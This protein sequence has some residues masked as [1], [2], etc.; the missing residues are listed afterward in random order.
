MCIKLTPETGARD[1]VRGAIGHVYNLITVAK[2]YVIVA[3][4]SLWR[5]DTVEAPRAKRDGKY[6]R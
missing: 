3:A 2:L 6:T 5:S 1:D 4:V